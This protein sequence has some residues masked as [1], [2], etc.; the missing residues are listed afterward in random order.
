MS[1]Q[2]V[3]CRRQLS[4]LDRVQAYKWLELAIPTLAPGPGLDAEGSLSARSADGLGALD[5]RQII[6]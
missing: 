4:P 3:Q 2:I 1:I 6:P 5:T